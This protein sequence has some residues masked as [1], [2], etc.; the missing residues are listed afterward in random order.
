MSETF[1]G[2]PPAE[3]DGA[4]DRAAAVASTAGDQASSVAHTTQ[5]Q[6]GDVAAAAK[7]QAKAVASDAQFQAKRLVSDSRRQLLDQADQQSNRLAE[8][9]REISEQLTTVVRGGSPPQGLVA[10]LAQQASTASSRLADQ[11]QNRR[12]EELLD[13]VRRFA[14]R[15]PGAFL[16]G[17]A[18]AGLLAGR[19]LKAMDTSGIVDAAKSGA[20]GNG[21]DQTSG[22]GTVGLTTSDR[23]GIASPSGD[24]SAVTLGTATPETMTQAVQP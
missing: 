7:E 4:K 6:V 8:S 14:R 10:D 21:S 1:T 22:Q 20:Q 12:P 5:A 23:F 13:E 19:M 2:P 15:R 11:L 17:A 24:P 16:L 9:V 18:G 3:P